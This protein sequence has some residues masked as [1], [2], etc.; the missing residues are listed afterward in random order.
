MAR[1][2]Y[3]IILDKLCTEHF[4]TALDIALAGICLA[5]VHCQDSGD[6]CKTCFMCCLCVVLAEWAH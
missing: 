1:G 2:L 5:N 3:S 4:H 6:S